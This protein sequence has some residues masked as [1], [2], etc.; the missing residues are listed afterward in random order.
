MDE[1]APDHGRQLSQRLAQP[2][3]AWERAVGIS[4]DSGTTFTNYTTANGLGSDVVFGV[5]ASGS[6]VY[7][8][9]SGGVSI[10]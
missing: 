10:A 9:T 7:A 4:T 6:T 1:A 3:V 2:E 5:Y 8:A